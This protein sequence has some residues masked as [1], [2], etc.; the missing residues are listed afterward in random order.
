MEQFTQD[1]HKQLSKY[2]QALI[3]HESWVWDEAQ[4]RETRSASSSETSGNELIEKLMKKKEISAIIGEILAKVINVNQQTNSE[5]NSNNELENIIDKII[6]EIA[7]VSIIALLSTY[8]ATLATPIPGYRP[9][10]GST[11]CGNSHIKGIG[12][13]VDSRDN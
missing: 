5:S 7:D 6:P 9:S 1:L 11:M 12:E 4:K 13:I 8:G 10:A 2:E 3:K